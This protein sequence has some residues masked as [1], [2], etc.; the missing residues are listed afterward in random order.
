MEK[1]KKSCQDLH[2]IFINLEKEYD[3]VHKLRACVVC[4]RIEKSCFKVYSVD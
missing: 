1:S 3:R 2:T 4:S